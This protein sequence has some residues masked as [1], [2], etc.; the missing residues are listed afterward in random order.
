MDVWDV[1]FC[2]DQE[3]IEHLFIDCPLAK[4]LWPTVNF[5]FDLPP[6]TNVTNMFGNWLNGVDRQFKAII[7]IEVSALCYLYEGAKWYYL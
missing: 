3:T 6:P 7:Q 4:L 2:G 5:T 1:F